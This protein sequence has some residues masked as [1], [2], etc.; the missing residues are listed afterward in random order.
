MQ[1]CL[2]VLQELQDPLLQD[3]EEGLQDIKL[4]IHQLEHNAR[5]REGEIFLRTEIK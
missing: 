4:S 1:V 3:V 2:H 5:D